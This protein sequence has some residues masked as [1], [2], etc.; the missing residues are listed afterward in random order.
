MILFY[1]TGVF[2]LKYR[3]KL[4]ILINAISANTVSF[5]LFIIGSVLQQSLRS[6]HIRSV[7]LG[8]INKPHILQQVCCNCFPSRMCQ[9]L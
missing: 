6:P 9:S 2:L 7:T 1:K 8:S 4:L 3:D 5:S